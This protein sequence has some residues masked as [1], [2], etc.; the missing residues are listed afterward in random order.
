MRVAMDA[1]PTVFVVMPVFNRLHF[2]RACLDCLRS[3]SYSPLRVIVVD[4]GSSDGT[5][6][7]LGREYPEV[8]LLKGSR[9]LWWAGAMHLGVEYA[10]SRSRDA[11]DMLL[12][13]N[14][15]TAVDPNYVEV[16]ARVSREKK[17]AVGG[18]I[19]DSHDP[20]HI[21][22][23]GE[24]IDWGT[25]S[26]PVK[27]AVSPGEDFF[28]GVDVLPGRG[29]LVPLHMIRAAGNVNAKV[30]PHYIADYEFFCRLRRYGFRLGVSYQAVLKAHAEETG[31]FFRPSMLTLREAWKFLFSRKSMHNVLDHW[32][33]IDHCAPPERRRRLK[34]ALVGQSIGLVAGNTKAKYVLSPVMWL[35]H[36]VLANHRRTR[37]GVGLI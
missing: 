8:V 16:L 13:M 14:N 7:I 20:S 31:L 15:D 28:D 21:L 2:T 12:M 37:G 32:H 30:F 33:F 1:R 6:E 26:F 5:P 19:V 4:G 25:Y 35:A 23:G 24:F 10:L 18:L 36:V 22:D 3:Q 34:L 27:T 11:E 9:E 29:T 17:A